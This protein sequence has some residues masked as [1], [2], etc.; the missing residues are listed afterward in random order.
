MCDHVH[1][2][3]MTNEYVVCWKRGLNHDSHAGRN[4]KNVSLSGWKSALVISDLPKGAKIY[5]ADITKAR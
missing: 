3:P 4:S 2:D 5:K 1:F